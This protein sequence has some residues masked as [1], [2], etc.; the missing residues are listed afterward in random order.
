[1]PTLLLGDRKPDLV[2]LMDREDCDLD[3]LNETYRQFD[4]LNRLLSGWGGIYR[5]SIRPRLEGGSA[6]LLDVGCGGGDVARFLA[7]LAARDEL[8][9][10]ITGIDPDQRAID[11]A[12]GAGPK[13]GRRALPAIEWIACHT[14]QLIQ[15]E[16]QFDFVIS[17]HVLHHLTQEALQGLLSDSESLATHACLHN[18]ICRDDLAMAGFQIVSLPFRGSFIRPDGLMSI[19]KSYT[20]RELASVVPMGWTAQRRIPFRLLATWTAS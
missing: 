8:H 20:R 17:N 4:L 2:E 5:R 11:F 16:R 19:R 1:M 13:S 3:R 6:T 15:E 18:D 12:R 10:A 7:L 9:L 14:S